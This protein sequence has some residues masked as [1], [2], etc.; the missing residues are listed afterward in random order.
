MVNALLCELDGV[1]SRGLVYVIA[2]T[3]R[4]EMLDPALL[5]PGRIAKDIYC[6]QPTL[7]ERYDF[8]SSKVDLSTAE[9]QNLSACT[10]NSSYADLEVLVD[11]AKLQVATK[12]TKLSSAIWDCVQ[13]IT[14]AG[15]QEVTDDI[16]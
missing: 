16:F 4:P 1:T 13:P 14:K 10:Q 15:Q 8:L 12:E 11:N 5:R 3:S 2:T 9:L 6:G 7:Q